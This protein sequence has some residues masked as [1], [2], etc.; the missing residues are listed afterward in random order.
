MPIL[1][2]EKMEELRT[3]SNYRFSA[4]K[5]DELGA[6][7]YTL[8]TIVVDVSGS[9]AAFKNELENSLKTILNLD[10]LVQTLWAFAVGSR[11]MVVG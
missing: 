3:A 1:M 6:T 8:A 9:V 5:V 11:A 2:D 4:V 7:K 10:L